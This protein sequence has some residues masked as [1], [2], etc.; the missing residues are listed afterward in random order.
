LDFNELPFQLVENWVWEWAALDFVAVKPLPDQLFARIVRARNYETGTWVMSQLALAKLDLELHL[1]WDKYVGTSVHSIDKKTL[2]QYKIPLSVKR[3]SHARDFLHVFGQGTGFAAGYYSYMWSEVLD[4]D[5][6]TKFREKGVLSKEVGMSFRK[7]VLAKG[8]LEP[9]DVVFREFMGRDPD[10][11]A[12]LARKGIQESLKH[13]ATKHLPQFVS[14]LGDMSSESCS[15]LPVGKHPWAD[16]ETPPL[17][18]SRGA[19][20]SK[21]GSG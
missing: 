10:I 15:A 19:S 21:E 5:V 18:S 3:P 14:C 4:A 20:R 16:N 7:R 9:P 12:M 11:G 1:D 17:G 2:A 6:F 8:A 13:S